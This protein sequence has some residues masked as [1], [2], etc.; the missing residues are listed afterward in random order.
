MWVHWHLGG[1]RLWPFPSLP[2]GPI[3]SVLTCKVSEEH[4]PGSPSYG[5]SWGPLDGISRWYFRPF[6]FWHFHWI[7]NDMVPLWSSSLFW[8]FF[9]VASKFCNFMIFKLFYLSLTG[10]STVDYA[11]HLDD[12]I[13]LWNHKTTSLASLTRE[14]ACDFQCNVDQEGKHRIILIW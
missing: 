1:T 9:K 7:R 13:T 14:M 4:P 12:Y 5:K 2:K 3:C 8:P 11:L 10:M 6:H